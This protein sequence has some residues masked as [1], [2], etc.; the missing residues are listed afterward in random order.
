SLSSLSATSSPD[1]EIRP[2]TDSEPNQRTLDEETNY[3]FHNYGLRDDA[4]NYTTMTEAFEHV[5]TLPARHS[6]RAPQFDR[7][8][9]ASLRTYIED[10]EHLAGKAK[11][12]IADK[13]KRFAVYMIRR[14]VTT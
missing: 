12:D 2:G 13:I 7:R 8:V 1:H 5:F 4:Y 6:N 11:L 14:T 10:Y 3:E 9:P